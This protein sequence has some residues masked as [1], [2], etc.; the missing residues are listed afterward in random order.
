MASQEAEELITGQS[1]VSFQIGGA[2]DS[3]GLQAR[4]ERFRKERARARRQQKASS[5]ESKLQRQLSSWP[6]RDSETKARLRTAFVKSALSYIGAPYHRKY[7]PDLPADTL[8]LD[9]CGL[10]RKVLRDLSPE[11]GFTIGGWNQAY[12]LDTLP[13]SRSREELLPGDLIFW[14]G[15]WVDANKKPF[16]FNCVHVE[17]YLGSRAECNEKLG[18]D[19]PELEG[20]LGG[21]ATLGSRTA[22]HVQV[23][24]TYENKPSKQYV[25]TDVFFRSIETWLDGRC[26]PQ[27]FQW[28]PSLPSQEA[29]S[30]KSVFADAG[31]ESEDE[32]DAV[33]S[34]LPT[35]VG[36]S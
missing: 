9:C 7:F 12:Q 31:A 29:V 25:I 26:E 32:I 30:A 2:G 3:G 24:Q 17:V 16:K 21:N 1:G 8:F 34:K 27:Q 11:F 13:I 20:V 10:V 36:G 19:V 28:G 5:E 33:H 35:S 15:D 23:H 22:G 14:S 6:L 18:L 4:F